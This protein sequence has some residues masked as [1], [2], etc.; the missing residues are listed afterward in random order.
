M[1]DDISLSHHKMP[2]SN[3]LMSRAPGGSVTLHVTCQWPPSVT[4]H[5]SPWSGEEPGV[6]TTV[7]IMPV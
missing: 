1:G 7:T 4:C 6:V 3:E 2:G 5:A